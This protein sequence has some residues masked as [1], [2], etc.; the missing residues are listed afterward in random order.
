VNGADP[1][2]GSGSGLRPDWKEQ[3]PVSWAEDAY[4]TR[5]EFTK[6]LVMVSFATFAASGAL[7]AM[8]AVIRARGP[9]P[10]PGAEISELALIPVGGSRVFNY[11]DPG[12][13]CLLLRL[14]ENRYAAYSQKCTHLGCPVLFEPEQG[15]LHCPCHEG[16]FSAEDGRVL[17]GPPQRPLPRILLE[18][19]GSTL[20]AVGVDS[21]PSHSG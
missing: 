1:S 16:Y 13:P 3:F 5:R 7:A 17:S 20:W 21:G 15:V 4:V 19:R 8:A 2:T 11:P 18:T 10:M 6:S 9:V 12:N 14:A